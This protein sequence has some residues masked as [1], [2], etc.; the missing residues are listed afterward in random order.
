MMFQYKLA[1]VTE[2]ICTSVVEG[3]QRHYPNLSGIA[4]R[5]LGIVA[6]FVPSEWLF[7]IAG[8]TVSVKCAALDLGN[9]DKLVFLYSNLPSP[10]LDYKH[11]KCS[12]VACSSH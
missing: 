3:M 10:H 5:Y 8:N 4:R 12:C 6:S 7:S 9:V 2:N 1:E 11:V